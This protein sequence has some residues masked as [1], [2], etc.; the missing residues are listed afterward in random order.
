MPDAMGRQGFCGGSV[1][2]QLCTSL[3]VRECAIRNGGRLKF[4][5]GSD[6]TWGWEVSYVP[7]RKHLLTHV[8]EVRILGTHLK[9]TESHWRHVSRIHT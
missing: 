5:V 3:E 4:K 6:V 9:C 2:E 8:K 1:P 7:N